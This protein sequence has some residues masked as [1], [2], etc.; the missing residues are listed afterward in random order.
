MEPMIIKPFTCRLD[1]WSHQTNRS[2][3]GETSRR[4]LQE[5]TLFMIVHRCWLLRGWRICEKIPMCILDLHASN[6]T[7]TTPCSLPLSLQSLHRGEIHRR[8]G[9]EQCQSSRRTRRSKRRDL[10]W[11][12]NTLIKLLS[13]RSNWT[14]GV[15][16]DER[17]PIKWDDSSRIHTTVSEST[18]FTFAIFALFLVSTTI[19][20]TSSTVS[21]FR[22]NRIEYSLSSRLSNSAT[23]TISSNPNRYPSSKTPRHLFLFSEKL[24]PQQMSHL[25]INWIKPLT[26]SKQLKR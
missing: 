16:H 6:W 4:I 5:R 1:R 10:L 18:M 3:G 12:N 20:T 17:W 7:E 21:R 9:K 8:A 2:E 25:V 26:S 23:S 14:N 22:L 15:C 11:T 13:D 19:T 24:V